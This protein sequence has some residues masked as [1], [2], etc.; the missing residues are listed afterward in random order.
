MPSIQS[1]KTS[2]EPLAKPLRRQLE[3]AVVKARDVAEEAAR[4]AL[5][6]PNRQV[7]RHVS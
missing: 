3:D 2:M 4:A 7:T 1:R 5:S 6:L